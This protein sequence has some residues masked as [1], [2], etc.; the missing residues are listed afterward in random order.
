[1]ITDKNIQHMKESNPNAN[2]NNANLPLPSQHTQ[3]SL[4]NQISLFKNPTNVINNIMNEFELEQFYS[5]SNEDHV[6]P[7]LTNTSENKN[8]TH[9]LSETNSTREYGCSLRS[10]TSENAGSIRQFI[11]MYNNS[12]DDFT[13]IPVLEA[14]NGHKY[15]YEYLKSNLDLTNTSAHN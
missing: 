3:V 9:H 6:V 8:T 1:M 14:Y 2:A 12:N 13:Y 10:T 11:W 5:I 15:D 4:L 7:S